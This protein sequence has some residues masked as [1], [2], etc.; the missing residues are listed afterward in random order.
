MTPSGPRPGHALRRRVAGLILLILLLAGIWYETRTSALQSLVFTQIATRLTYQPAPGE[1]DSIRFPTAGPFDQRHGFTLLPAVSRA[2][3]ERGF[4]VSSQAR[5][6][7]WLLRTVDLGCYPIYPKKARAGLVL[8]DRR[9]E[10]LYLAAYPQRI[11]PDF[12]SIPRPIVDALLFIENRELLDERHEYRNPAVEWDRL[13][14][15]AGELALSTVSASEKQSGGSTL[16]TQMEK[17][18]HSPGGFT[19]SPRE[20][21][22]QILSASLRSYYSGRHT[23][24]ARK[25]IVLDYMNAV[26][27]G[28]VPQY[29]EVIGLGDGLW[30]W[31]DEDFDEVN[32][33]LA[34][35]DEQNAGSRERAEAYK[36]VLGLIVAHRRPYTYLTT[37]R[38]LLEEETNAYL[39]ILAR[40]GV[41]PSALCTRALTIPLEFRHGNPP[42]PRTSFIDKKAANA[43]RTQL[44]SLL[45]LDQLYAL[46]RI[47]LTAGTTLDA[48]LQRRLSR[49]FARLKSAA[50]VDSLRLRGEHLLG[51]GDLARVIYSFTLFEATPD[52]NLMRLQVE[53]YDQPLD[54][55]VG[56][57]LDLGS[58]AKLRTLANYLEIV[59]D[60]HVRHAG[61]A[62]GE[63]AQAREKAAD[64][65]RRWALGY[66]AQASD[67][68]LAAT[69]EAALERRYSASPFEQFF[70]GGGVHTFVNFQEEDNDRILSVGEALRNSVNLV[71]IRLMRDIV[72]YYQQE[73]PGYN[74][75]LL[76]DG[77]DPRRQEYLARFADREGRQFLAQFYSKYAKK[78]PAE[79]VE[80]LAARTRQSARRL[81][82]LF[83]SVRP[84]AGP[85][86][87]ARFLSAH[88]SPGA[89]EDIS[90]PELYEAYGPEAYDLQ[91]RAYILRVD[92]MELWL[93][94]Y[95]Q[96][97]P[98]PNWRETVAAGAE[99]RQ[100]AYR[101]LL[102]SSSVEKQNKRI[103]IMLE[104]D[105]FD[106]I[107]Q[108]WQELGY[109]FDS[110]VPSYASAIGSS[111][112]RPA[113]L[114]EL[115]GIIVN[116]GM[117]LPNRRLEYLRF[118]ENT[119]FE[120]NF[121]FV[122]D[123]AERV[124]RVEVARALRTAL[125]DVVENGT[126][127]RCAHAFRRKDGSVIP[128]GGKTG[129]GD[130]RF[131]TFGPGGRL[132]ESRV[133][134]RAATFVFLI[135]DRHYGVMTVLVPGSEAADYSFTSSLP[136][137]L[138]ASLAPLLMPLIDE[139]RP[140]PA[141]APPSDGISLV[142]APPADARPDGIS[143]VPAAP[144]DERPAAIAPLPGT[145]AALV[146]RP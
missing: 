35:L 40:E 99:A 112:D 119:P 115:M 11:Y 122:P 68:T 65:I 43:V 21:A 83:R 39:R 49:L 106:L 111:A 48:P 100:E 61:R 95:L 62:Q 113:A 108:A 84:E 93:V 105:A 110:F 142:Q 2:L 27:L 77:D 17:F 136:V 67:T 94:A 1:S 135:G 98:H 131:E 12:A 141:T 75:L 140:V 38:A 22:R 70:T 50:V 66:L 120:T 143:L 28:A 55:S 92:P 125:L 20:K 102:T 30:A 97:H 73:L 121:A 32:R 5:W 63:L 8:L 10:P 23:L 59:A 47:D 19:S 88:L 82:T 134:S 34:G 58:S 133:V 91:D 116:D 104:E 96:T 13:A 57:K 107:H 126:A 9:N 15:A 44:L 25:R 14:R 6:S 31:F 72:R 138:L 87:L 42:S 76:E 114:A 7:P 36:K 117:R 69:L 37:N 123:G 46:D 129:T 4:V 64:P 29:G 74:P 78:T 124:M 132:K 79:A 51:D 103:R 24:G 86:S 89:L 139:Q 90:V 16:A 56:A 80:M 81:A 52:G 128:V 144:V 54:L 118:A 60:L 101:W 145:L 137:Q 33:L 127:R 26:P 41:I 53:N 18:L 85:D 146:R 3:A 130:S 45:Q 71:F 109:P